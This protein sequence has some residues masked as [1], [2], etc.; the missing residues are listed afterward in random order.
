MVPIISHGPSWQLYGSV[1]DS[2]Y[3]YGIVE[4]PNRDDLTYLKWEGNNSLV[5]SWL[6][7]SME[8]KLTDLFLSMSPA[9]DICDTL[10]ETYSQ[11]G[12][13]AQV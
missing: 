9:K 2:N 10:V 4:A 1:V 6:V 12:N 5:M 7:H 8:P 3:V 11:Q 13:V